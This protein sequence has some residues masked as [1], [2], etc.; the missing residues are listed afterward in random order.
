MGQRR[1]DEQLS[2]YMDREL[3][4]K[5][6]AR[7]ERQLAADPKMRDELDALRNTVSLVRNLPPV[8]IPRNFILRPGSIGGTSPRAIQRRSRWVAPLLTAASAVASLLFVITL[9]TSFLAGSAD[10]SG[11]ASAPSLNKEAGAP[12]AVRGAGSKEDTYQ[13]AQAREFQSDSEKSLS[14]EE[15]LPVTESG[16]D[17]APSN[18]AQVPSGAGLPAQE[19]QPAAAADVSSIG[20]ELPPHPLAVE[21][22]AATALPAVIGGTESAPATITERLEIGPVT[23][24]AAPADEVTIR[25]GVPVSGHV[26]MFRRIY[27][28]ALSVVLGTS[29]LVLAALTVRAWRRQD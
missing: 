25:S 29:A 11:L 9:A 6:R 14:H 17:R 7:L 8:P 26:T 12:E 19:E 28:L 1:Q 2:A 23:G 27:L 10:I 3:S 21:E 24:Q 13:N 16:E 15:S 4:S 5:E 18:G 22:K 20:T